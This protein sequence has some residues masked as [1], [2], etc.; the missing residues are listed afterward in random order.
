MALERLRKGFKVKL[1]NRSKIA[2]ELDKIVSEM[3][4]TGWNPMSGNINL[5]SRDLGLCFSIALLNM[6]GGNPVFR[7]QKDM[8]HFSIFWIDAKVEVFPFHKVLKCLFNREGETLEGFT[9]GITSQIK[10]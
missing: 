8:N 2:R 7:S 1:E 4:A 5:F 6:F 10:Q 3:W 9:R